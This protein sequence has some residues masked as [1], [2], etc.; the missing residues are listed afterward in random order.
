[1]GE[2]HQSL[3]GIR[4]GRAWPPP[5]PL[6]RGWGGRAALGDEKLRRLEQVLL[7]RPG[8]FGDRIAER[9]GIRLVDEVGE[10]LG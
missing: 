3:L 2:F 4:A 10:R 8:D 6:R 1:V 9:R 5:R 7:A